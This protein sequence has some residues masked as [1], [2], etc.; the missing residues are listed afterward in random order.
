MFA[1]AAPAVLANPLVVR[2]ASTVKI[3]FPMHFRMF[4]LVC[5]PMRAAKQTLDKLA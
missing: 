2:A 5:M 1:L 3:A 4:L